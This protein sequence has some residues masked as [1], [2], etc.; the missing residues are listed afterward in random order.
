MA[1]DSVS[2]TVSAREMG[3]RALLALAVVA[4]VVLTRRALV[5]VLSQLLFGVLLCAAAQVVMRRLPEG[6]S[7]GVAAALSL[8]ALALLAGGF[9]LL[10][11]PVT[12]RQAGQLIALLPGTFV[13]LRE[14]LD[15]LLAALEAQGLK[16]VGGAEGMALDQAQTLLTGAL[17]VLAQGVGGVADA[18]SK[19]MFAPV[20]AFYFLKDGRRISRWLSTL[21]PIAHR[22][23]AVS[24]LREMRREMGGFVRGQLMISACV[25]V[26]TGVGLWAAGVPAWLVLGLSMGVLEMIPYIGPILGGVPVV[27]FAIP[28]GLPRVLWALGVVVAVQQV[29]GLL[30]APRLLSQATRLHPVAVLLALFIGGVAGGI[31]GM[32]AAIPA[33]LCVR[34]GYR[35]FR[36]E[37]R[38]AR[39]NARE[40]GAPRGSPDI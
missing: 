12:F 21:I 11:L 8:F 26:L 27:L 18:F 14:V 9:L 5:A 15:G 16:G 10:I 3:R 35:V 36:V 28:G 29:E 24:A 7:R 30:L 32:L 37:Q 4:L 22:R 33:L 38:K 25:G 39:L 2:T 34:A 40:P 20:F 31:F 23:M 6:W 17:N 1:S 19:V 13:K